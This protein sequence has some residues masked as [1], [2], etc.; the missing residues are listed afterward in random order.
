MNC[1]NKRTRFSRFVEQRKKKHKALANLITASPHRLG[2]RSATANR[3]NKK[4]QV[5]IY[6][7]IMEFISIDRFQSQPK[8]NK[9]RKK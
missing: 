3:Q 5:T 6:N 2:G 9:H 7:V 4:N 1:V 8:C